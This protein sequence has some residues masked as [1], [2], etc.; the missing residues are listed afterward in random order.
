MPGELV[1]TLHVAAAGTDTDSLGDA[2]PYH[3]QVTQLARDLTIHA[4]AVLAETA[5][6]QSQAP[7]SASWEDY[8]EDG[9]TPITLAAGK[10]IRISRTSSFGDLR[11]H[12]NGGAAVAHDFPVV[13]E[14]CR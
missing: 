12:L 3:K 11:I 7:G 9:A 5:T 1:G 14:L 13:A 4:P 6:I 8:T 10:A 2:S